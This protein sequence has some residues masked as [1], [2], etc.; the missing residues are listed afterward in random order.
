MDKADIAIVYY[1]DEVVVHKKL[2][3]LALEDVQ[4]AFGNG[5]RIIKNAKELRNNLEAMDFAN[6]VLL[7]MSSGNFDGIQFEEFGSELLKRF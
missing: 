4:A 6:S 3:A 7:M 5:V 1:N 2:P